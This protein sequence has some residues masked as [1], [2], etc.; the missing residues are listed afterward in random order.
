M[1]GGVDPLLCAA[2]VAVG[3]VLTFDGA[4]VVLEFGATVTAVGDADGASVGGGVLE[5]A[6]EGVLEGA[7]LGDDV[8]GMHAQMNVLSF[9]HGCVTSAR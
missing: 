6:F 5:G 3:V 9:E 4:L 2:F 8:R 1:D 7:R